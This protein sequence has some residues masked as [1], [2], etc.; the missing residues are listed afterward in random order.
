M[1]KKSISQILIDSPQQQLMNWAGFSA[2]RDK[3]MLP[4]NWLVEPSQNC[5]IPDG[6]KIIPRGGTQKVFQ[7][8]SP[9]LFDGS[10]GGYVKFKNFYGIEMDVKSY[11]DATAG[12]QVLVLFNDVYVPITKAIN[13]A[14]NGNDRIYFSTYSDTNLNFALNK[15][16]PRLCWVNGYEHTDGKGR[17]FS[18]TGGIGSINTVVGNV[19]TLPTGQT[20]RKLGFTEFFPNNTQI[21]VTINGVEYFSTN[22]SEL[23]T[24][25]LTLNTP[26][27]AV[28]GDVV[29]SAIEVDTLI[30]P[31]QMLKMNKNYMYYGNEKY[32]QWWMSNQFGRPSTLRN[33]GTNAAQD[34]LS[35]SANANY[36]GSGSNSYKIVVSSSTPAK[37]TQ[38]FFGTGT[39]A[40]YFDTTGYTGIGTRRYRISIISNCVVTFTGGVTPAFVV[41]ERIIGS[42]SGAILKVAELTG[43]GAIATELISGS[44]VVGETF[45]GQSS[46]TTSPV[47]VSITYFNDAFFYRQIGDNSTWM[48]ITGLS[49]MLPSGAIQLASTGSYTLIDGITFM[50]PQI[51]ANNVGDYYQLEIQTEAPDTFTWQMNNGPIS[52]PI[53]MTSGTDIP[54]DNGL[55]VQFGSSTGHQV[56]DF[57]YIHADQEIVRPWANFYYTLDFL[58]QNSARKPGEGYVYDIP[59]N[60]WTMDTFESSMYLNTSNGEWGYTTPTLSADLKSEDISFTP[61]KQVV[62]SKVLYQYLT[63]H[64][65]NDLIYIDENRNLQSMG[66]K[67]MMEKVQTDTMT[68]SVLNK[69]QS[70]SFKD[71]S[72]MFN[73]NSISITSPTDNTMMVWNERRQYWQPPQYI[74]N[75]GLL[76]VIGT[77]LYV[78]S[79]LDSATRSIDDKT[80]IGDDGV[81]YEVIIRSSTFDHGNRWIK[82]TANMAFWEGYIYQE[83]PINSMK[84]KMYLDPDGCAGIKE[85]SILPVYC[86]DATNNGNFGGAENGNHEYG[87]DKTYKTAYARYQMD[88]L[89]VTNFYFSS[90]E[91]TCRAK[92]HF[93]EVLSMG[94]NVAQSKLNNKDYRPAESAIDS[95]LPL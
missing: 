37:N 84:M 58:T 90:I 30:A 93:Y 61:L 21:H 4:N 59:A 67:I 43:L 95:L 69:F 12:E 28:S 50:V 56:G 10:I 94:I 18:W 15:R 13:T 81:E 20:W 49:G 14:L 42:I 88:K 35:V 79:Y 78:H 80:A 52:A 89:G 32:R 60:F 76:T 36:T 3:T 40:Y 57:W 73:D 29:T 86:C 75:L 6:D 68:N 31:M 53:P 39:N 34:D 47:V 62:S 51:G 65:R 91:F 77:K 70:L 2:K 66:R 25:T 16:L 85:E 7:G 72:I 22:L 24:N 44:P 87:S 27:V 48:Q 64:S 46:G 1:S 83:L 5:L 33:T 17:V 92:Q 8:N 23:D 74:P 9:V 19:I 38:N 26:P 71:G 41:G 63:G 45:T 11:R 55:V 82:K 54:I